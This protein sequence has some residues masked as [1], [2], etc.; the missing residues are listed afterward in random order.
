MWFGYEGDGLSLPRKIREKERKLALKKCVVDLEEEDLG[1]FSRGVGGRSAPLRESGRC[2][3][4]K[5]P[6]SRTGSHSARHRAGARLEGR[7]N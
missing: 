6:G 1:W 3:G 2:V 5:N 7:G 4:N